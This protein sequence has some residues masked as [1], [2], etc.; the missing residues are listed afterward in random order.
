MKILGIDPG[1]ATIGFALLDQGRLCDF[2]VIRTPAGLSLPERLSQIATDLKGLTESFAP[3][4]AAIENLYFVKNITNGMLVA[5]ARGVILHTLD[6]AG[7]PIIEAQPKDIKISV[8][9]YGN[10]PKIQIQNSVQRIFRLRDLPRPDDAADAIAVA[11]WASC[12]KQSSFF[13]LTA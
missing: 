2:G 1:L 8:C 10:A 3:D 4:L 9:G 13:S 11:F 5:H 12:Q 7:V 6:A